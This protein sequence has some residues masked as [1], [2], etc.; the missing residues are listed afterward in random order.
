M[1]TATLPPETRGDFAAGGYAYDSQDV[2]LASLADLDLLRAVARLRMPV[3]WING[4]LDQLRVNEEL[5]RRLSPH[6]ELIVVPRTTHLLPAMRPEV[7][8]AM[9]SLAVAT[10]QRDADVPGR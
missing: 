5:F 2:A 4:A 9:L 1:L 8:N 3:W 7:F 6:S 10:L